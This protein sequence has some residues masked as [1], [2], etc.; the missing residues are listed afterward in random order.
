M[1]EIA[2]T[3]IWEIGSFQD[4]VK[5]ISHGDSF[6]STKFCMPQNCQKKDGIKPT[7]WQLHLYPNGDFGAGNYIS[8]SLE[9]IK[10]PFEISN[11]INERE[12]RHKIG[13]GK[14]VDNKSFMS[15]NFIK[16]VTGIKHN[17]NFDNPPATWS[18]DQLISLNAIFPDG[19]KFKSIDIFIQITFID[20]EESFE[21]NE[22]L[23]EKSEKAFG[24][25]DLTDI[26]FNFDCDKIVK[27]HRVILAMGSKYFKE[28]FQG[29]WKGKKKVTIE[30]T[31]CMAFRAVIYFIYTGKLMYEGCGCCI[32]VNIHIETRKLAD[33]MG[34]T[35]L[36]CLVAKEM[37]KSLN[38]GNWDKFLLI[39]WK[40]NDK[41]LKDIVLEYAAKNWRKFKKG[42]GLKRL[43]SAASDEME[44][45]EELVSIA[46][47]RKQMA[48]W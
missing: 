45:I 1:G 42:K 31:S 19:N 25:E 8:V 41:F 20:F 11:N 46:N 35:K 43:V 44:V 47:K 10:T 36:K 38:E 5:K 32:L 29:E 14:I 4:Y 40:T 7:L 21:R 18:L 27:A 22:I 30:D 48:I 16:K 12:Q 9:A 37:P 34:L 39:G 17:Y 23:Y 26:E 28:K 33:M 24:D 3:F 15:K 2:N 13:I 6:S